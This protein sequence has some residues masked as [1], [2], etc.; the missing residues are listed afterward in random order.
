VRTSRAFLPLLL[1]A[2]LAAP[3]TAQEPEELSPEVAKGLA[4]AVRRLDSRGHCGTWSDWEYQA[5][6]DARKA[7]PVL[8]RR[9]KHGDVQ[10]RR[11]SI[12]AMRAIGGAIRNDPRAMLAPLA[13][14]DPQVRREAMQLVL[15]VARWSG[16]DYREPLRA[17]LVPHLKRRMEGAIA[18]PEFSAQAAVAVAWLQGRA[19][20]QLQALLWRATDH[21]NPAIA[22]DAR[23]AFGR[24]AEATPAQIPV[25][26]ERLGGEQ[27]HQ[28]EWVLSRAGARAEPAVRRALAH[29]EPR[30]RRHAAYCLA[31]RRGDMA[32]ETIA[33]L[34]KVIDHA[35]G[36]LVRQALKTLEAAGPAAA[37][38][39]VDVAALVRSPDAAIA[40][41]A[42]TAI[43]A[44]G[45]GSPLAARAL[46]LDLEEAPG[47]ELARRL[48][49]Y[50]ALGPSGRDALPRL[51]LL[52]RSAD[53]EVAIEAACAAWKVSGDSE[54]W[55]P[56]FRRLIAQPP[57]PG[58]RRTPYTPYTRTI[59]WGKE[60]GRDATPLLPFLCGLVEEGT[61][62]GVLMVLKELPD[63]VVAAGTAHYRRWLEHESAAV[64]F[65]GCRLLWRA[66]EPPE[67][68]IE[69]LRP[70]L[71][72]DRRYDR[73]M[74]VAL[75]LRLGQAGRPLWPELLKHLTIPDRYDGQAAPLWISALG[76][77]GVQFLPALR[78][79]HA[80]API[81]Q[82]WRVEQ[83]IARLEKIRDGK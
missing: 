10:T 11:T 80:K 18:E 48:R 41:A 8:A 42:R 19:D 67:Q 33:E 20:L 83:A 23:V 12:H 44:I 56:V 4:W 76:E 75:V 65:A 59:Q 28:A 6:Y 3:A 63:D 9:V 66:G 35:D 40:A 55:M 16:D 5:A 32:A 37:S 71:H 61:N 38:A 81:W 31:K 54:R 57:P 21:L 22:K 43:V 27:W 77:G 68:F 58:P 72:T 79:H 29:A 24:F 14:A 34:Q 50:G 47:S 73:L 62:P 39:I 60:L 36:V 70:L 7:W 69:V 30:V 52:A 45:S 17:A 1:S 78:A 13:D 49:E 82:L 15:R 2:L 26:V 64:R 25:L 51:E 53:Q 74:R 46:R